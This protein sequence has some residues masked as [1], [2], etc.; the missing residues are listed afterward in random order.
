MLVALLPLLT[1]AGGACL[2]GYLGFSLV[3]VP[4]EPHCGLAALPA[5]FVG[6]CFGLVMGFVGLCVGGGLATAL[7]DRLVPEDGK[8]EEDY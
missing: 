6:G 4:T 7:A 8:N 3:G 5:L 2:G 1:A